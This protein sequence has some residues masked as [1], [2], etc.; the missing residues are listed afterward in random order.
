MKF[1]YVSM[2]FLL[3]LSFLPV[4]NVIAD[5]QT[6]RVIIEMNVIPMT[7][8]ER[9]NE[10][11]ANEYKKK[12][13][14]SKQQVL[15]KLTA[16]KYKY[17][18][19]LK[20]TR[21]MSMQVDQGTLKQISADPN[22]KSVHV[23]SLKVASLLESAPLVG[24]ISA[25]LCDSNTCGAGQTIA[26]L[27]TGID[28]AHPFFAGKILG[29]ACFSTTF[30][31]FE[32]QSVCPNRQPEQFGPGAGVSCNIEGCDHGTHVAGIAVGNG[33]RAEVGF[34]GIAP[35]ANVI[36]IQVFSRF[37]DNDRCES[38]GLSSPCLLAYTSDIL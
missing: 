8:T 4:T 3:L 9:R 38:L 17:L 11:I 36:P 12:L 21:Y 35:E 31:T 34:S 33:N 14:N 15:A 18:K 22:V 2:L 23:D 19:V 30:A 20:Y 37:D 32:S 27:D 1:L 13:L 29:E 7:A 10:K 25:D 6:Q 26:I 24:A 5:I 28:S 16:S